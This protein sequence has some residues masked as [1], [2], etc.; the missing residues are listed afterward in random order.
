MG[1]EL[2]LRRPADPESADRY[3]TL[4]AVAIEDVQD[5]DEA[6]RLL[7]KVRLADEAVRLQRLGEDRER[8]WHVLVLRAERKVGEL[9]GPAQPGNKTG[10][11]RTNVSATNVSDADR[12]ARNQARKVAAVPAEKFEEYVSTASNPTRAG[13]LRSANGK[14]KP[15]GRGGKVK[16][17]QTGKTGRRRKDWR[18]QTPGQR[19]RELRE[20][21]R[22]TAEAYLQLF[23]FSVEI[24]KM[25]VIL[26][27]FNVQDYGTS[28][29]ELWRM[30]EILDDLISLG[31]WHNV[32]MSVL[33]RYMKDNEVMRR[34]EKL[35]NTEGRTPE[36]IAAFE[37]MAKRLE[38]KLALTS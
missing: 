4:A 31:E 26:E 7:D 5:P 20:Q 32:Q 12:V 37:A 18:G 10:R 13:L 29:V 2:E 38:R 6:M 22:S 9:L 24:A 17:Q 1:S 19:L 27:A 21:K 23:K 34:I 14:A 30:A 36:E 35:R 3:E 11:A 25:C 33:L 28:D 15:P 16:G 8:R